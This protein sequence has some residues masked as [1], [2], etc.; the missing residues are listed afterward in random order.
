[1]KKYLLFLILSLFTSLT[2]AQIQSV[3]L[4]NYFND[5]QKDSFPYKRS[6]KVKNML[7]KNSYSLHI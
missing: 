7:R 1:M 3:V 2:K 6:M 5:F 4:Q